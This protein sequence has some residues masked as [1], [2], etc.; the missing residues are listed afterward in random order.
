MLDAVKI[1][2]ANN[3]IHMF[4]HEFSGGMRQR[5]MIAMSLL[6]NPNIII[7]DEPTTSLDVTVQAQIM[8]LFSDI[9]KRL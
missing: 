5:V 2:N 4:P 6:C 7:A 8:E 3:R 9:Q 1:P